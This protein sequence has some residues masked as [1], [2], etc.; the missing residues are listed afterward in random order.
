MSRIG[1][2]FGWL[3]RLDRL[4]TRAAFRRFTEP[5]IVLEDRNLRLQLAAGVVGAL[6]CVLGLVGWALML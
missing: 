5:G 2:A 4:N 6:V 1:R 3:D